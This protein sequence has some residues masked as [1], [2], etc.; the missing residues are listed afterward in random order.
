MAFS[1]FYNRIQ[2]MLNEER[3]E[4][5]VLTYIECYWN[6]VR[7]DMN[8]NTLKVYELIAKIN[9]Q[10][11]SL[12]LNYNNES[13]PERCLTNTNILIASPTAENLINMAHFL[14][15]LPIRQVPMCLRDL[16]AF[17]RQNESIKED[18]QYQMLLGK[19]FAEKQ[20]ADLVRYEQLQNEEEKNRY[21]LCAQASIQALNSN[22]VVWNIKK[23]N[24]NHNLVTLTNSEYKD[25]LQLQ[26]RYFSD[27]WVWY[28]NAN[29][30]IKRQDNKEFDIEQFAEQVLAFYKNQCGLRNQEP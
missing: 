11:Y 3:F 25:N 20:I 4:A 5:F 29:E 15:S 17:L 28:H 14:Y 21:D 22:K 18:S 19:G 23:W 1:A 12:V 13:V 24:K 8:P 26:F 2:Q 16:H 27:A 9:D 6:I 10:Y 7:C 30:R